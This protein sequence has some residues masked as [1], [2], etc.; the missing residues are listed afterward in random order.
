MQGLAILTDPQGQPKTVAIDVQQHDAQ[1]S[2]IVAGLLQL[3]QQQSGRQT[4]EEEWRLLAHKALN[5]A[6]GDDEPDYDDV[7]AVKTL[8]F[9]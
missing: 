3:I 8:H 1:L 7:P 2:P 5:R 9:A 6:Y 4:E